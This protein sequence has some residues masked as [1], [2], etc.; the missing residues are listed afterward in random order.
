MQICNIFFA[1]YILLAICR[2]TTIYQ[3][4]HYEIKEY[5]KYI[6][7]NIHIEMYSLFLIL[8]NCTINHWQ[9]TIICALLLGFG[10]IMLFGKKRVRL[11]ITSRIKRLWIMLVPLIFFLLCYYPTIVLVRYLI[12][13]F[14]ILSN[15][16]EGIINKGYLNKAIAKIDKFDGECIAITGSFGKTSC[17]YYLSC[18]LSSLHV[19]ST[20]KSYNTLNGI[21]IIINNNNLDLYDYLILEMGSSHVGEIKK[22]ANSF[23][24]K[25]GV[26]TSIGYMHLNTFKSLDNIIKEKM[27][28]IEGLPKNGLGI[29]NYENEYIRSYSLKSEAYIITYGL[30]YGDFKAVKRNEMVDINYHDR[31]VLSFMGNNLSDIDILN[32]MPCVIISL[33]LGVDYDEIKGKIKELKK[34]AHRQEIRH[35]ENSVVIDDSYNSNLVGATSAIMKMRE[36]KGRKIIITPGIVENDKVSGEIYDE[37]SRIINDNVDEAYIVKCRVSKKLYD[38]VNIKKEYVKSVNDA[39]KRLNYKDGLVIL[40]E[41]DIPDI[42]V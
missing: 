7:R 32:L 29:I 12:I 3:Q 15:Y 17:K 2:S 27:S 8:L 20:I 10:S 35:I 42:Y 22:L 34:P 38:N 24:P 41:N 26:V 14:M 36:Y 39:L 40:I 9:L 13:L 23:K 28:L 31:H 30:N 33:I 19:L 25:I 21:S 16:I 11:K 4:A 37:Y 1:F 6:V 18:L 5:F